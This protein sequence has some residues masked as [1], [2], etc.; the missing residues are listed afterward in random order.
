MYL[1]QVLCQMDCYTL[2]EVLQILKTLTRRYSLYLTCND[3]NLQEIKLFFLDKKLNKSD[4]MH[5]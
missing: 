4:E 3:T 2:R 5:Y 1:K